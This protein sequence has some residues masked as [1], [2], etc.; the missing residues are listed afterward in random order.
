MRWALLKRA[1]EVTGYSEKAIRCKMT[2]GVW[3]K[4]IHWDKAPDGHVIINLEAVDQWFQGTVEL[5]PGKRV[6]A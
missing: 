1:A 2:D 3:L 5:K 6:S 4:G